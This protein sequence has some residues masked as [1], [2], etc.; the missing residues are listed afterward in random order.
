MKT[1]PH[2]QQTNRKTSDAYADNKSMMII[3]NDT[4]NNDDYKKK[5]KLC[6]VEIESKEYFEQDAEE[7]IPK[8]LILG[9]VS[10]IGFITVHGL[11]EGHIALISGEVGW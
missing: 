9:E 5:N 2:S 11:N 10:N 7:G 6:D 1:A 4:N 8:Y 3:L